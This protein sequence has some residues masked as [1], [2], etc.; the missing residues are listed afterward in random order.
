MKSWDKFVQ[1]PQNTNYSVIAKILLE[2]GWENRGGKGSH[3]IWKKEGFQNLVF[4][5]HGKDCKTYQKKIALDVLLSN[6]K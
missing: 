6:R 3:V 5:V 2:R 1:S 4:S